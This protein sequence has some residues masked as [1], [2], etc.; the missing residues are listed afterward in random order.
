MFNELK[1]KSSAGDI[2]R[3]DLIV[4]QQSIL[5]VVKKQNIY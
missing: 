2:Y 4:E 3:N 5:Q 1:N